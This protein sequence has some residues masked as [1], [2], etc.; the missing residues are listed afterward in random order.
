MIGSEKT[1]H[2]DNYFKNILFMIIIEHRSI[3][4]TLF[5]F[6]STIRSEVTFV[7]LNLLLGGKIE[8]I[9]FQVRITLIK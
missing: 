6:I 2:V 7:F 8:K 9:A 5:Y 1:C 3:E 4:C